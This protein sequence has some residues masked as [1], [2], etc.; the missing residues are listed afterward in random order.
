MAKLPSQRFVIPKVELELSGVKWNTAGAKYNPISTNSKVAQSL[1]RLGMSDAGIRQ[2]S[3]GQP[4]L[5]KN[6]QEIVARIVVEA[7]S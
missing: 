3:S 2:L 4:I 5:S 7:L 6:D 1:K